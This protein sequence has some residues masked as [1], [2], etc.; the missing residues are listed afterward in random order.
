[1]LLLCMKFD[2]SLH[3]YLLTY[4]LTP[5]G[6][7][8]SSQG[9]ICCIN[10]HERDRMMCKPLSNMGLQFTHTYTSV[11]WLLEIETETQMLSGWF[12]GFICS[13]I[14]KIKELVLIHEHSYK[15]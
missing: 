1:M 7:L 9:R 12:L 14:Y 15:E 13:Q 10:F 6:I 5:I 11:G 4:L 3:G 2:S 8:L